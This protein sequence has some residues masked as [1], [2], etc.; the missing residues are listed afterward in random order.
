MSRALLPLFLTSILFAQAPVVTI[1][2]STTPVVGYL[3][4]ETIF[5]EDGEA[6]LPALWFFALDAGPTQ[7]GAVS[8]PLGVTGLVE[9]LN[10]LPM[11]QGG[12]TI[13]AFVPNLPALDGLSVYTL[14][15]LMDPAE[16]LGARIS[17]PNSVMFAA[18]ATDAGP[19]GGTLVGRAVTLDGSNNVDGNGSIPAGLTFNWTIISAPAGSTATLQHANS[20]YPVLT[21]DIAGSYSIG[22]VT[23][24]VGPGSD[25]TTIDAYSIDFTTPVNGSFGSGSFTPS[26]TA[27]GPVGATFALQNAGIVP[28]GGGAFTGSPI[29]SPAGSLATPV[30]MSIVGPSGQRMSRTSGRLIGTGQPITNPALPAAGIRVNGI[31]LDPLE[32][33][34]EQFLGTIDFSSIIGLIPAI[35]LLSIPGPFNTILFSATADPQTFTFDPVVDLDFYP[36]PNGAIGVSLTFTN[37]VI[38]TLVTGKIF[39]A[40]YTSTATITS[41]SAVISGNLV[42]VPNATGAQAQ[43]QGATTTLNGFAF[44][45]TGALGTSTQFA[46]V[47][48][49]LKTAIEVA[50]STTLQLIPPLINPLLT[51]FNTFT[52]DL[53]ASGIPLTLGFPLHSLYYDA[54]GLTVGLG[55]NFQPSAG[56]VVTPTVAQF[57]TT[58]GTIPVFPP[59]TPNLGNPY[60]G[61]LALNDDTLNAI[62]ATFTNLGVLDVNLNGSIGTG[63]GT[64][65]LNAGALDAAFPSSGFEAFDPNTIVAVRFTQTTAPAFTLAA[66]NPATGTFVLA[67]AIVTFAA[68][69]D[70]IERPVLS[71]S[72]TA[73]VGVLFNINP[74]TSTLSV[75]PGTILSTLSIETNFPGRDASASATALATA[76][77]TGVV[78]II[79]AIGTIPLAGV[80]GAGEISVI[81]DNLTIFF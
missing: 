15:F 8:V 53:G 7:I 4:A 69:V 20:P 78:Q 10:F 45:A 26:G 31:S 67:N 46:T 52:F 12:I 49:L 57:R 48:T 65:A 61:G 68:V 50:L 14:G 19:D 3:G 17:N 77:S 80:G 58:P 71:A 64:I 60:T 42:L 22:L 38:T 5:K 70:G 35:P 56:A 79:N 32:P 63:A 36:G 75:T 59:T 74:A 2:N 16:P 18:F 24:G 21:P 27:T 47:Q 23:G 72:L 29:I 37:V 6:G 40:P 51:Q 1:N 28:S 73:N 81:G 41:T 33:L 62:F 25:S 9:I 54:L 34:V 39:N 13:P 66:G 43:I 76:L 11:P 30:T 44:T 55:L